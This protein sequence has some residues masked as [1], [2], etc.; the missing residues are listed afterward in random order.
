M[1]LLSI[2]TQVCA[3]VSLVQPAAVVGSSDRQVQQLLAIANRA[4]RMLASAH[5]WQ[6][7]REEQDFVTTATEAQATAFAADFDRFVPNSFFNRTTRREI[8]GPLTPQQ[9]Q[10]IKAQPV[11]AN[12]YLAW[13]ERQGVFRMVPQPPAGQTI[14][15]EYISN[16][17]AKSNIGAAQTAYLADTDLTYLSEDLIGLGMIWRWKRAK[18]N[19]YAEE[20][21]DYETEL[22][23]AKARDGGAT[24][25]NLSP[26]APN[27]TRA[28]VPDGNFGP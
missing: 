3:E 6:G 25:L 7:L 1:S 11:Y 10:W 15:Y 22:E 24:M 16:A 14:A 12:V 9:Y 28:N 19:D 23:K 18:G 27:M 2:V 13:I 21:A 8:V 17:W 4:G 5:P 26:A 20:M